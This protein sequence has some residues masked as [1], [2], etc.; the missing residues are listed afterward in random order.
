MMG[1]TRRGLACSAFAVHMNMLRFT[2]IEADKE[3]SVR[4]GYSV[5]RWVIL[6]R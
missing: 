5:Y 2:A 4:V 6:P 1:Y 3:Q